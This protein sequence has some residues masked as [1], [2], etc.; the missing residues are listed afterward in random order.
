MNSRVGEGHMDPIEEGAAHQAMPQVT[1]E[2]G[3]QTSEEVQVATDRP[4]TND[5]RKIHMR[6]EDVNPGTRVMRANEETILA[7]RTEKGKSK[8]RALI[9]GNDTQEGHS[10]DAT[11]LA[12]AFE[13]LN[14]SVQTF[15]TMFS[16]TNERSEKSRGFL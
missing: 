11:S 9:R 1:I 3:A 10:R 2:H 7:I 5:R 15:L 16:R 6:L 8:S 13:P 14:R 4:Q 12:T